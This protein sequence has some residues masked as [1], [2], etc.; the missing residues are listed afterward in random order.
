MFEEIV[1]LLGAPL[2]CI[3]LLINDS[4]S[5]SE[6]FVS[7]QILPRNNNQTGQSKL[8]K[9]FPMIFLNVL[10]REFFLESN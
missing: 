1:R 2:I 10:L 8:L 6:E 3:S 9:E 7:K 4:Y 5:N